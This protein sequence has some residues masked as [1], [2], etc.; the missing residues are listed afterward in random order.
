MEWS[1]V[2]VG[3]GLE[4]MF[5]EGISV[6]RFIRC[7]YL[8]NGFVERYTASVDYDDGLDSDF[9]LLGYVAIISGNERME[10]QAF[11]FSSHTES[12]LCTRHSNPLKKR[13]I[14]VKKITL[15]QCV[16]GRTPLTNPSRLHIQNDIGHR[17][18]RSYRRASCRIFIICPVYQRGS[19]SL[20]HYQRF[21]KV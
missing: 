3:N 19:D 5:G 2:I 16:C 21:F 9:V 1:S 8:I 20:I 14:W 15:S 13:V 7:S 10:I 4:R 18:A 6:E 17:S 12:F 11:S